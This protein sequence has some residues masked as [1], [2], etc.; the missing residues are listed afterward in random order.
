[1]HPPCGVHPREP[2][3]QRNRPPFDGY[4]LA[5]SRA[6]ELTERAQRCPFERHPSLFGLDVED[7]HDAGAP[8]RGRH[9]RLVEELRAIPLMVMVNLQRYPS[10]QIRVLGFVY[11]A[12]SSA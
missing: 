5:R 1:M 3:R 7:A 2:H 10:R 11:G 4:E 8:E 9:A 6:Y 12:R